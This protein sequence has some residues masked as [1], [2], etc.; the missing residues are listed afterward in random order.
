MICPYNRESEK[1]VLQETY[2]YNDD[3]LTTGTEQ[4]NFV[5]FTL[6]ECL[7]ANCGAWRGNRCHYAAASFNN[8]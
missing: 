8:E 4:L 7:K 3:N 5:T 2:E 1:T 6:T